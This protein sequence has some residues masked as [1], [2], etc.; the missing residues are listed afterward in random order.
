MHANSPADAIVRL[1]VLAMS[2]DTK[3]SQKAVQY[4]IGSAVD[5]IIQIS[6][7]ADGTR[8][9]VDISEVKGVDSQGNYNIVPIYDLHHLERGAEGQMLGQ[10]QATGNEPSFMAEITNNKIPIPATRFLKIA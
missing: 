4:Q 10:L 3:I 2:G 9:I 1:E 7:L 8:R 5:M 6:R